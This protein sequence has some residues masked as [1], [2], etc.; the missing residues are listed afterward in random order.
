M[1]SRRGD[2]GLRPGGRGFLQRAFALAGAMAVSLGVVLMPSIGTAAAQ[3]SRMTSAIAASPSPSPTP[4]S[5]STSP[6]P[7]PTS[8]A[9]SSPSPSPSPSPSRSHKPKPRRPT[10]EPARPPGGV[11]VAGPRMYDP[12]RNKAYPQHSWVTVSQVNNLVNQV[13]QVTWRNFSPSSSLT[14]D[15]T[16]TDYPVMVAECKGTHPTKWSQCF[17][18]NNGGVAGSFSAYGPMNTAYSTTSGNG[19]G[20]TFIQLLTG[21][22]NQLLGCDKGTPCSLVIVPSQGG[23]IFDS[24]PNCT[25]HSQDSGQTD[26]GSLAFNASFGA[27]SWNKR[28]IVPMDFAPTPTDCPV[29]NPNFSAIG[30]PMLERAMNSWQSALCSAASPVNIQYDSA[31]NEPL[32]RT[33]FISGNDDVAFTTLPGSTKSSVHPVAYAPVAIS[34][35]S[36][37]FWI[38]NPG[39]GKPLTHVK[40][41][42]RL[43]L[44]LLTQSYDFE[45]ESCGKGTVPKGVGCDNAVDNNPSSLFADPEFRKLN[46]HVASVGDGFQI[47]TVLSGLS[48]MTWELTR[49]IAGNAAARS[50]ADGAF[51]PWGMHVNTDYLNM[52]LPTQS[53][54]SMD[55]YLPVAHRYDPVF[56][57]SQVAQYQVDNWYP[58]TDWQPD[59]QGNFDKLTPEIPG[60]RALFAVLDEADAAA[61]ELPVAALANAAGK[62]VL[63]T[64]AGM[65]GALGTMYTYGNHISQD[66]RENDKKATGAYPLTMV[67][68]AMVP[69]GGISK[70]KARKI[71]QF[72]D[73]VANAGQVQGDQAGDLPPGYLPLTAKMRAQ[74][75]KAA[76]EVLSQKGSTKA[77]P[78]TAPATPTPKPSASQGHISLGF[79]R[80]P[81]TAGL[82]RYALPILLAAGALL[83]VAGSFALAIGRGGAVAM[84]RLRRVRLPRMTL[85]RRN[86]S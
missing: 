80:F 73:F 35:E 75:L 64:D 77:A 25:D 31:Q 30:S 51:D 7:S 67:I 40:L 44:K 27:C 84:T 66:V 81:L 82:I 23:N 17:G 4:T 19:T 2:R 83:A 21:I 58:A 22:E 28:V 69:T 43:V 71:A 61:Y 78:S 49:W 36:I 13:V 20:E 3:S 18:A 33:D 65:T 59:A 86:K 45:F 62:Y 1:R 5:P 37:A 50:F 60:D 53:L 12:A 29:H 9:S 79:V 8:T 70:K 42:P 48:D 41:D 32:A 56:P 57:L 63:P 34:A 72:L 11:V 47:P 6:S 24:P 38:D 10:G 52:Q 74:T 14:Y 46:P 54:N 68:Y 39:T 15:P 85:P 55:P 76:R 16:S 26:I